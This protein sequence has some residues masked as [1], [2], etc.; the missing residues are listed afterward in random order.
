M[1]ISVAMENWK[2]AIAST[3]TVLIIWV[4]KPL[5][6]KGGTGIPPRPNLKINNHDKGTLC[7]CSKNLTARRRQSNLSSCASG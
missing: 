4:L 3:L 2:V 6:A 1:T 5:L 7:L